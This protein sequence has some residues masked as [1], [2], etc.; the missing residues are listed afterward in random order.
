MQDHQ[1]HYGDYT[2]CLQC[3]DLSYRVRKAS[4]ENGGSE[5]SKRK[6]PTKAA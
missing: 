4:D 1:D 2:E 3:G 5:V 6:R